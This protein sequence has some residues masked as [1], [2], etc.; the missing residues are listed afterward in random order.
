MVAAAE[1]GLGGGL[2]GGRPD[3]V[4]GA[5]EVVEGPLSVQVEG[6]LK[7]VKEEFERLVCMQSGAAEH[8][9]PTIL[10]GIDSMARRP[11]RL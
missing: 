11:G 8:H 5:A 7:T 3:W 10:H 9:P 1:S 2:E 6:I 4:R